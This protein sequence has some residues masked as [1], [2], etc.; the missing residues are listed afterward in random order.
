MNNMKMLKTTAFIFGLLLVATAC[1]KKPKSGFKTVKLDE[2]FELKMEQ[3][4]VLAD[5]DFKLTFTGV[6]EESRCPKY[7]NCIQEGQ[8]RLTMVAVIDGTNHPFEFTRRA[9]E[10]GN[11]TATIGKYKIQLYDVQPFPESEKTIN[12]VDY[13]ARMAIRKVN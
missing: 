13:K 5:Q 9:S 11:N 1:N 12:L 4:I 10:K 8:V 3:S 6:P 7:T 2:F